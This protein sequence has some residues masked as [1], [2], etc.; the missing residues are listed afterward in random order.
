M[1]IERI[2]QISLYLWLLLTNSYLAFP[3]TKNLYQGPLKILCSPGL[4]CYSCPAATLYCPIGSIQQLLLGLR[5]NLET[6][7][8]FF[9]LYIIGSLGIIGTLFGRFICGWACPFG[10]FQELLFK[11][12]PRKFIIPKVLTFGKYLTLAILVVILPLVVVDSYQI[13]QPWFCKYLCPTGTIEAGLPM[14]LLMP[15]LRSI[16]G[17]LFFFKLAIAFFFTGWSIV[18]SRPFCRTTCPLG[19]FYSFFHKY[20]VLKLVHIPANCT[21]CKKCFDVCPVEIHFDETPDSKECIKCLKCKHEACNFNAIAIDVA[22]IG[23]F[24]PNTRQPDKS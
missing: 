16:V 23:V 22:G 11:I 21:G 14:L 13:G 4:N 18:A 3:F 7:S 1:E 6:G 9:G 2:R 12:S 8:Y 20:S 10:L 17:T 5:F 15:D 24:T 19:A